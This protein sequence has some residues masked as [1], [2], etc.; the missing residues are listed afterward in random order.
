MSA[1]PSFFCDN[2]LLIYFSNYC[3]S[4]FLLI[5]PAKWHNLLLP[6][7]HGLNLKL[8]L[9]DQTRMMDNC[10]TTAAAPPSQKSPSGPSCS[11][12]TC[13]DSACVGTQPQH[14]HVLDG[15]KTHV[16]TTKLSTDNRQI[17]WVELS[18]VVLLCDWPHLT[19]EPS[20]LSVPSLD[21]WQKPSGPQARSR[22][23]PHRCRH[24]SK[25]DT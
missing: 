5:I 8:F 11:T 18:P 2:K 4:P 23:F 24:C 25:G 20:Q 13:G 3:Y 1:T 15:G 7:R 10:S 19:G 14:L 17:N 16:I 12:S 21:P 9:Y 6:S 22:T